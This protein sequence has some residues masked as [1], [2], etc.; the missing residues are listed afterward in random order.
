MRGAKVD[1]ADSQNLTA[2]MYATYGGHIE[3]F[4]MLI[5]YG[6]SLNVRNRLGHSLEY[7]AEKS[8]CFALMGAV[9]NQ[10][11]AIECT[12][13]KAESNVMVVV[14]ESDYIL[15][16]FHGK[17]WKITLAKLELDTVLDSDGQLLPDAHEKIS[18]FIVEHK[19]VQLNTEGKKA[20]LNRIE[21]IKAATASQVKT[22][23]GVSEIGI[24]AASVN[25]AALQNT[26]AGENIIV[27]PTSSNM[28]F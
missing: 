15:C 23:S 3:I 5:R 18:T 27:T 24:F 8:N 14:Q 12:K 16:Y 6:A 11:I 20:I 22:S 2:L 4:N 13:M 7:M 21:E 9:P 1:T 10:T 28:P 17:C 19:L 26:E 25:T